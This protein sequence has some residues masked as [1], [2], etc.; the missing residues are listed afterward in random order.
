[1]LALFG[2]FYVQTYIGGKKKKAEALAAK[3]KAEKSS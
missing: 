1:M 2:N 3:A